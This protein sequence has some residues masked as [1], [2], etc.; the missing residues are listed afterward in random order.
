MKTPFIARPLLLA[1]VLGCASAPQ[2]PAPAAPVQRDA[3]PQRRT[4]A[5]APGPAAD[6][7]APEALSARAQRLFAEAVRA[8]EDQ[9]KLQ[10]PTDWAV[11]ERRWRAVLDAADVA[12]VHFNVGVALEQQGRL[13]EARAEYERALASKPSLRQAAVNLGV[14]LEKRGDV[15]GAQAIYAGVVRDFPEDARARARLAAL[16]RDA[17]QL[18]D[19]WRLAREALLRDPRSVGAYEVLVRV[20]AQRNNLDLAKLIALRAQ[21]LDGADPELPYLLGVIAARQGDDAAATVQLRKALAL[22]G[23][24]LPARYA[25]LQAAVKKESWK[26]VAEHTQA[27]L[28]QDPKNAPVQL[29]YGIALRHLDKPDDALAAYDRAEQVSAGRLPEVHLARGVL[30]MRVK[31]E[32]EPAL[33]EF[34]AYAQAA[35]PMATTDSPVLKLQRECEQAVEEGRRAAEVANELKRKAEQKAAEEAARKAA[36][37]G[38]ASPVPVPTQGGAVSP[39]SAQSPTR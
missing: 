2:R 6:A 5:G 21:K 18:D 3:A 7:Q 12:E 30:Y 36:E 8:Q 15:Q 20:A 4:E 26:Q 19:A 14:L 38:E 35:G 9:K 22:D 23:H 37:K 17:G 29:A 10:V 28:A 24:Y 34:R 11:L 16:Y 13:D 32:C 31:S 1:A 33:K 27:I 39:T 25:L